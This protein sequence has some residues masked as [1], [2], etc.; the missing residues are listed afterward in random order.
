MGQDLS[1]STYSCSPSLC[2]RHRPIEA[3]IPI[4][5]EMKGHYAGDD[6]G[7]PCDEPLEEQLPQFFR[8]ACQCNPKL[9]S[10]A[11][12]PEGW[13]SPSVVAAAEQ[14]VDPHRVL[15]NAEHGPLDSKA[16]LRPA[17]QQGEAVH[18]VRLR[19]AEQD[20]PGC[21]RPAE[22]DSRQTT[23]LSSSSNCHDKA[24]SSDKADASA[25][26]RGKSGP[27]DK[28]ASGAKMREDPAK[29]DVK[30]S[31]LELPTRNGE[32]HSALHRPP[33]DT[34]ATSGQGH[35]PSQEPRQ[36]PQN[37]DISPR[38]GVEQERAVL[39]FLKENGFKTM[40]GKRQS[41]V[42]TTY[43]LH[44]AVSQGLLRMTELLL[45]AAADPNQKNSW[46]QTPLDIAR[47]NNKRGSH[48]GVL[49]A[50][51]NATAVAAAR[52]ASGSSELRP[53]LQLSPEEPETVPDAKVPSRCGDSSS[54]NSSN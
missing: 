22:I 9:E 25:P 21:L 11:T 24:E 53:T 33:Q 48:M 44:C 5:P 39:A 34:P 28:A 20:A 8:G 31:D 23:G 29:D 30:T 54:D 18:R 27:S 41:L 3:E 40:C 26:A 51:E 12:S 38:A 13:E 47:K 37:S 45:K 49:E 36:E 43:P 19:D 46:G 16:A 52:K 4:A 50:L 15:G 7:Y 2:A 1:C 17:E 14:L 32:V 42:L 10:S 6:D 35:S